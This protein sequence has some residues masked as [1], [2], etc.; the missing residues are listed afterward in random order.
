MIESLE[1]QTHVIYTK[2]EKL[3]DRALRSAYFEDLD[4]IGQ[5]YELESRKPR[6]LIR[7]PFQIGIVVYQLAKLSMLQF[8][9]DF[10]YS[11]YSGSFY[12]GHRDVKF[13]RHVGYK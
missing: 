9:Y 1:R 11:S 7:R 3:V 6:I 13:F 4:D 8:Y 10:G 2:D 12:E 5:A